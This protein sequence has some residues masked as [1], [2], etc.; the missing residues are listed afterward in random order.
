MRNKYYIS[1]AF[2]LI[3]TIFIGCQKD[4]LNQKPDHVISEELV[5]NSVDKLKRLLAGS[6]NEI[7]NGNYLGRVLY[8]R[9]AVKSADFRFVQTIYNPRNYEQIEYRYEESGNNNGSASILWLQCYKVIG[10]LNL[11]LA[12]IDRAIGDDALRAQIKAESLALRGMVYFDLSRTFAYPW[13]KDKGKSQGIP[14]K[15]TPNELVIERGT[16][17]QTYNQ[18]L[19][20]LQMAETL[21]KESVPAAG[22]SKYITKVG[23]QALMARVYLYQENWQMAL[24]YAQKVMEVI[25]EEKLMGLTNYV[26]S[27]YTSESIFELSVTNDNSPGSNGLGAQFDFRAGGQGDI[28]ATQTF[29]DLLKEYVADPRANLLL[30]DKEGTKNAFVKYINRS[31]GSG[32]SIHNIPVIRLSEIVLIAAEACAN[33]A[34]AG[35]EAALRYLNM[36]IKRRT[37]DF[38][39]D[40]ATESGVGLLNRIA[41]ERRKELALEGHEIYDLIRTGTALERKLTDHI[42]TGLNSKNLNIP[43]ISVKMIYPIPV[44]EISA[45]GMK[46]TI[47]Y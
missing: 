18:I 20:D 39:R 1:G 21:L 25:P 5:I 10:N 17:A 35:E 16:L 3:L 6:Y 8:K 19:M 23:V 28:L 9:S 37:G 14:L 29:S 24:H 31:G 34:T 47:G 15:L 2:M 7:S 13:I 38:Q 11:I 33:G 26:F 40:G 36:L 22:S 42:N 32:L 4:L 43:A 46:Q 12:N 45:S 30:T 44:N 41:K 27:D